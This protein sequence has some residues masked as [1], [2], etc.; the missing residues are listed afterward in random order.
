MYSYNSE[1][2]D[3]MIPFEIEEI[4][5]YVEN[6]ILYELENFS[7]QSERSRIVGIK[8]FGIDFDYH[9]S[10]TKYLQD[11]QILN[12]IQ[13]FYQS[14]RVCNPLRNVLLDIFPNILD[15]EPVARESS[16]EYDDILSEISEYTIFVD[17]LPEL[18]MS[19]GECIVCYTDGDVL[20]WPCH[21]SH[22]ICQTCTEKIVA[23]GALCPLCRRHI[24][25]SE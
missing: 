10:V 17:V 22:V 21:T 16:F 2:T 24:L 1:L 25:L 11:Y 20:E 8:N 4:I 7:I 9:R 18:V 12:Q 14:E 3:E 19:H 23:K 6:N 5:E 15:N 13:D